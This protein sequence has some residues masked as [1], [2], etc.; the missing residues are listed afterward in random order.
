M[1]D[2]DTPSIEDEIGDS[3]DEHATF[4]RCTDSIEGEIFW[5]YD[6]AR[7]GSIETFFHRDFVG[8]SVDIEFR[9]IAGN[10]QYIS[11]DRHIHI[12]S[13]YTSQRSYDEVSLMRFEHIDSYLT[14][15]LSM[16]F[17]G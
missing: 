10:R 3:N 14:D 2:F 5:E 15:I 8:L 11:R 1:L 16:W 4:Y 17:I 9:P 12:A 6:R 13:R 7:E